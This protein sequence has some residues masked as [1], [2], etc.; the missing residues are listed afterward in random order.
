MPP[1]KRRHP[2]PEALAGL[3]PGGLQKAPT[4][5]PV[6]DIASVPRAA[7]VPQTSTSPAAPTKM[8]I[9]FYQNPEDA[10]RA[11]AAFYWTRTREGHRSFSDFVAHAI[12]AEVERLETKYN[13]GEPWDPM[14]PGE[15]PTGKPFGP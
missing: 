8:K 6:L 11:R 15:L 2:D 3:T 10:A 4:A 12:A 9:G 7:V 5:D 13:H 14:L 1:N